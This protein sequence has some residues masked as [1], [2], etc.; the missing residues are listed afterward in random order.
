[1]D[2]IMK[3]RIEKFNGFVM[4]LDIEKIPIGLFSGK[5]GICIYFYHQ[6][7]LT[8]NRKYEKFAEKL[9]DSIYRQ[10]HTE[11]PI[12]I[13]NGLA[14]IC[15]GIN[16]LI[17]ENFVKG[18]VN[19]IL[20]EL[21]DRI[22]R[23]LNF[24][25]LSNNSII[26]IENIKL[27]L[28]ISFYFSMRL[29]NHNLDENERFIFENII[30][31]AINKIESTNEPDKFSEPYFFSLINY[32]LPI[33]LIFLSQVYK[34][35]FYNYKIE[36]IFDEMSDKLKSTYP[37]LQSNRLYLSAGIKCIQK[38][39]P[40]NGWGD[41]IKLLEQNIDIPLI[42]KVDFKNKNI[43]LNNGLTGFYY[44]IKKKYKRTSF[45]KNLVSERIVFSDL[46]HSLNYDEEKNKISFGLVTGLSGVILTYQDALIEN[47][48]ENKY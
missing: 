36:K 35:N 8:Q 47:N 46:W 30:I 33:Y 19:S 1:M 21:D 31:K 17:E 15:Y 22:F 20:K 37:L 23:S 10:V 32:F 5:M 27:I 48:N 24:N 4:S 11:M 28:G 3:E 14:G 34:H 41:H 39:K 18:N 9:L 29:N 42:I 26:R 16:Y 7:R 45:D 2:A 6:A 44:L 13:E 43:L 12:D 25:S 40:M 38:L